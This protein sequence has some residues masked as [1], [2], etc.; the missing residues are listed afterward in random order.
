MSPLRG[1]V[2]S[3][4]CFFCF[5]LSRHAERAGDLNGVC[6]DKW[7]FRD[8]I[9]AVLDLRQGLQQNAPKSTNAFQTHSN[10]KPLS[11]FT[12]QPHLLIKTLLHFIPK[13]TY[14]LIIEMAIGLHANLF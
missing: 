10:K 11:L 1:F 3:L 2:F 13:A 12:L 9:V 8:G 6:W 4:N 14:I 7:D 5:L